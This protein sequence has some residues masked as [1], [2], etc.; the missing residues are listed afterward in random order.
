MEKLKDAPREDLTALIQGVG[1]GSGVSN[2]E[3]LSN[4]EVGSFSASI[5]KFIDAAVSIILP[6]AASK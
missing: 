4:T 3:V 1:S 5:T 6:P 2:T